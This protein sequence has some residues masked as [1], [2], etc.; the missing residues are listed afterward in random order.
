MSFLPRSSPYISNDA[1]AQLTLTSHLANAFLIFRSFG[2]ALEER[3]NAYPGYHLKRFVR[4]FAWSLLLLSSGLSPGTLF[5]DFVPTFASLS[6]I[7]DASF[8]FWFPAVWTLLGCFFTIASLA[9]SFYVAFGR[10]NLIVPL[11]DQIMDA[12]RII[13]DRSASLWVAQ[14]DVEALKMAVTRHEKSTAETLLALREL[15]TDLQA[16]ASI[17]RETCGA[18]TG[19]KTDPQ[20]PATPV[21]LEILAELRKMTKV[22]PKIQRRLPP[23]SLHLFLKAQ[24]EGLARERIQTT[25]N[26]FHDLD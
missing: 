3:V 9:V 25:P 7:M 5:L 6:T 15:T 11:L 12:L 18:V 16:L 4:P 13:R 26:P 10:R 2:P 22:D 21:L 24:A 14:R 17:A 1:W 20:A 8:K 23:F 19:F